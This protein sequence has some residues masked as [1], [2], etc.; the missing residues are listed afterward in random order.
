MT[1]FDGITTALLAGLTTVVQP[2][3]AKGAAAGHMLAEHIDAALPRL[4]QR[5]TTSCCPPAS[6]RGPRW[7]RRASSI[8]WIGGSSRHTLPN[9]APKLAEISALFGKMYRACPIYRACPV[10]RA[11]RLSAE[12]NRAGRGELLQEIRHSRNIRNAVCG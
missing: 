12:V 8:Y 3:K 6:T 1:G 5:T 7:A 4:P 2:N 9:I 11:S 10:Y